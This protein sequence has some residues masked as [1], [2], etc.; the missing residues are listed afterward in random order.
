MTTDRP[1]D[2]YDT[3]DEPSAQGARLAENIIAEAAI[4]V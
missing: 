2:V 4:P 1:G 3:P